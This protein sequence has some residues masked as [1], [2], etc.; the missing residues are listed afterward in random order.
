MRTRLVCLLVA[1][2][3]LPG[4]RCV[5]EFL[6]PGDSH[7]TEAGIRQTTDE[8]QRLERYED[9][10][11]EIMREDRKGRSDPPLERVPPAY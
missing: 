4:C 1:T 5:R 6:F 2:I 10:Q 3:L 9:R 7:R 8:R 11:N